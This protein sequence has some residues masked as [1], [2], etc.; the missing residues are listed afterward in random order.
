VLKLNPRELEVVLAAYARTTL[1]GFGRGLT[2]E[3]L[4]EEQGRK[5]HRALSRRARKGAEETV[6]RYVAAPPVDFVRWTESRDRLATRTAAL[7][8]DD[9]PA[10]LEGMVRARSESASRS[11]TIDLDDDG[12]RDLLRFWVSEPALRARLRAGLGG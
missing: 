11:V 1:A 5:I 3:D 12:S 2:N 9:L 7:L 4:I 10:S 6:Q 8:C